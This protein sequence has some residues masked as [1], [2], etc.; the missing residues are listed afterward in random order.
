MTFAMGESREIGRY[1]LPS[2]MDLPALGTATM[3]ACL[4]MTGMSASAME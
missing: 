3:F 4:Q 1:E 2:A